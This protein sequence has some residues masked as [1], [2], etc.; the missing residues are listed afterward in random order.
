[1]HMSR[2]AEFKFLTE[3]SIVDVVLNHFKWNLS[4]IFIILRPNCDIPM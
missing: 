1:M 4:L 2:N 3:A